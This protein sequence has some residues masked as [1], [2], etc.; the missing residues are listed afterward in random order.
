[1]LTLVLA[2]GVPLPSPWAVMITSFH[3]ICYL[4]INKKV[5]S[6]D[7]SLWC[8]RASRTGQDLPASQSGLLHRAG[9]PGHR[10]KFACKEETAAETL[11]PWSWRRV[12]C[13]AL[14]LPEVMRVGN[15]GLS[16]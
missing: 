1:M 5:E 15:R 12:P 2:T 3:V 11:G 14:A 7:W 4:M 8:N 16:I 10:P 9:Q 6:R 13:A